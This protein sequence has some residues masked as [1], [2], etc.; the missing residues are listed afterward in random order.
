MS[1]LTSTKKNYDLDSE[2]K[3][4]VSTGQHSCSVTRSGLTLGMTRD[5]SQIQDG[6]LCNTVN[7]CDKKLAPSSI[8]VV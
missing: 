3:T 8:S 4:F 5:I 7:Y 1:Y 6:V 2:F